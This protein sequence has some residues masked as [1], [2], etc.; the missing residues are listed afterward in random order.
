MKTPIN[1]PNTIDITIINIGFLED[2]ILLTISKPPYI[3]NSYKLP[4]NVAFE[5]SSALFGGVVGDELLKRIIKDTR[6]RNIPYLLCEMG[7]DQRLPMSVYAKSK[8]LEVEFYKD[9]A[10][11]DRGFWIKEKR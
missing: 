8:G 11:L 6:N 7:Y 2:D 9:L 10:G 3:A 5:P 4:K 1:I